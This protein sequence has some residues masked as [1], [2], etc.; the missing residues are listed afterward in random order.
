HQALDP[1]LELQVRRRIVALAEKVYPADSWE[2]GF[3]LR[4]M[5][6]Y[7]TRP[8]SPFDDLDPRPPSRREEAEAL[9]RRILTLAR[10]PVDRLRNEH[11]R[12]AVDVPGYCQALRVLHAALQNLGGGEPMQP[13]TEELVRCARA[14]L[15]RVA[16]E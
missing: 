8:P 10:A 14:G 6:A 7:L 5:Y 15:A 3:E 16:S 13:V 4:E 2:L 11:G 9:R 12:S 1:V